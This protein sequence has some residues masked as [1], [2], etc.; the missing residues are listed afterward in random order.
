[1]FSTSVL[2]SDS[3]YTPRKIFSRTHTGGY[4]DDV[5]TLNT[6]IPDRMLS[7]RIITKERLAIAFAINLF[8]SMPELQCRFVESLLYLKVPKGV[9]TGIET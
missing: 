8:F 5:S 9:E 3:R 4:V 6:M 2:G 7:L 1:M